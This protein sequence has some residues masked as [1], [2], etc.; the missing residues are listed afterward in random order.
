[1]VVTPTHPDH[2]R[3]WA[4]R[5]TGMLTVQ[6]PWT[7]GRSAATYSHGEPIFPA[8]KISPPCSLKET[9]YISTTKTCKSLN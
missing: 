5:G 4:D 9:K 8:K 2:E 7:A 1:M 3:T 6:V